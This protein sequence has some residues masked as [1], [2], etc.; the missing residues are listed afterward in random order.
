MRGRGAEVPKAHFL[1]CE[2]LCSVGKEN[3]KILSLA[4]AAFTAVHMPPAAVRTIPLR[5]TSKISKI[6]Y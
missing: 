5:K 3:E 6:I 2:A 1:C 4:L